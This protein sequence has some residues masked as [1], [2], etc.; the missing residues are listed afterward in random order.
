MSKAL[1]IHV[2]QPNTYIKYIRYDS[3]S[4]DLHKGDK[5]LFMG[6]ITNSGYENEAVVMDDRGLRTVVIHETDWE[7]V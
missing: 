5:V 6:W 3:L 1:Q 7:I 4:G 2:L